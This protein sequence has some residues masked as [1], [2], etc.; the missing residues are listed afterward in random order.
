MIMSFICTQC[1]ECCRN[2]KLSNLYKDLDSGDGTCKYLVEN[3]CSIYEVR[4]LKCRIDKC[5]EQFFHDYVTLE[6]Y[7][8]MNYEMCMMLQSNKK[9]NKKKEENACHYQLS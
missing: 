3:L 1:G 6:E 7:Y 9:K 2:L 5:Y 8:Q 4:P